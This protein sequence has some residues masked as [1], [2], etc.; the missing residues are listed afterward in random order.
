MRLAALDLYR[1]DLPFSTPV[2]LKGVT[3][4]RREGLLIRLSAEDG[5]VGWGEATP[6]PGFSHESIDG[7]AR[8]IR[9]LAASTLKREIPTEQTNPERTP[10]HHLD[11]VPTL[12]SV[13]FAFE[14][15]L[16]NLLA[17]VTARTLPKLLKEIPNE[18]VLLNGLLSVSSK[19]VLADAVYLREQG[20]QAVKLKVGSRDV[21]ED[22]E[23]VLAVRRALGGG[24]SLRLDA[25]RGWGFRE[26]VAFARGVVSADIEYVEEPI[27]DPL[28]LP[29]LA[30]TWGLPV[31]LDES[32]V[33]MEPGDLEGHRYAR[34]VVLKPMLLGGI[35][36]ALS[37]AERA[38]RLGMT[39]VVSS[40]YESG[41]GTAA[42]VALA[43]VVGNEPVPAGL[44]TYRRLA[45]DVL[46]KPLGLSA[47]S[48]NVRE[49]MAASR[50]VDVGRLELLQASD[51]ESP[52]H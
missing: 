6:L 34:A 52:D 36:H 2:T 3:L 32:L 48:I 10:N 7:S 37:L 50:R 11:R 46:E 29:E 1:Y 18:T 8:Q 27:S 49:V 31:A 44:D 42:L 28:R 24:V 5:S 21:A 38:R 12:P 30:R 40:S 41:V 26:A 25:N 51:G 33:G 20:Y 35:S 9:E 45:G 14:L 17:T 39:P 22:V 16:W 4:R 43:A 47:P 13:R 23:L 19:K 15:A